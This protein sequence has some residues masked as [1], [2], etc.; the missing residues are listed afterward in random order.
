M[1]LAGGL[2]PPN[3]L[4]TRQVRYRLRHASKR[5]QPTQK[6]HG[7]RGVHT[8]PWLLG[9]YALVMVAWLTVVKWH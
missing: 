9:T 8:A 4:F 3:H 5:R 6:P 7:R 2:E 1:E